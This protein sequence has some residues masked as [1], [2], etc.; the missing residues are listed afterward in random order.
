VNPEVP[1]VAQ[2][3]REHEEAVARAAGHTIVPEDRGVL[4][5]GYEMAAMGLLRY[6]RTHGLLPE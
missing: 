2:G 3:L 1:Y 4:V 6:F 5:S